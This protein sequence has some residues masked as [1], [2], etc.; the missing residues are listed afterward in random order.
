MVEGSSPSLAPRRSRQPSA[1]LLGTSVR[2]AGQR[3]GPLGGVA[4]VLRRDGYE[5]V[6]VV[7]HGRAAKLL[8]QFARAE[9]ALVNLVARAVIQ[10]A[11]LQFLRRDIVAKR[12]IHDDELSRHTSGLGEERGGSPGSRWP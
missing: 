3:R 6:A 7:Q 2:R 8:R 1:S 10:H 12:C 4:R 5:P 9:E 11:F